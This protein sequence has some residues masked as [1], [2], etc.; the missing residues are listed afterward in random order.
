V[1]Y[2]KKNSILLLFLLVFACKTES[3]KVKLNIESNSLIKY[4]KGFDIQHLN[5][6]IKLEVKSPYPDSYKHLEYILIHNKT[7]LSQFTNDEKII[8][9]PLEKTVV[10]STTHIP[11]LELLEVEQ[12]LI[13]FPNTHYISSE[14]T[15]KLVE[16]GHIQELGND[17]SINTEILIDLKPD[18]VIA[19]A[20]S[21]GNKSLSTIERA[22]IPVIYNGDWLEESPLGRAEW[23][24]FFGVLY[25]KEQ[26]ADSIFQ[27]IEKQYISAKKIASETSSKPTVLSGAMFK[28]VWNLPAGE[29]FVA[30]FLRDANTDYLWKDTEG[31]GSLQL[32]FEN[33]LDKGQ[34]TDLWIAPGYFESKEQMLQASKHY[35]QFD[36]Y[37]NDNLYTFANKK[38]ANGGVIYYELAP[39]R[40]D[41]VLKDIIKI[42]HPEVLKDYEMTFF[43]KMK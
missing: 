42:A 34:T 28:D 19:F 21:G 7:D 39:T 35:E 6:Y 32:N 4:A 26:M 33:I 8:S 13:G 16:N 18:A 12:S 25:G 30:Q 40:P 1:N 38:G 11:M 41:L 29:S 23:L 2:T 17:A 15:S 20:M 22:E 36:A 10:T 24:K 37:R 31:K 5:D 43:E 9:I 14:I 27:S 3:E